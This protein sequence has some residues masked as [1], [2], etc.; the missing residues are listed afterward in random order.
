MSRH[1][2]LQSTTD[3]LS[4]KMETHVILYNMINLS[5]QCLVFLL[6]I[7]YVVMCSKCDA[8]IN[9]KIKKLFLLHCLNCELI[10][11]GRFDKNGIFSVKILL[12]FNG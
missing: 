1:K 10:K 8:L 7:V 11:E 2:P 9:N 12:Q 5:G 6:D 3:L 4:A